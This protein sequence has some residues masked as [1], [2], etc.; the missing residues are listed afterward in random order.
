MR[1][2]AALGNSNGTLMP[3]GRFQAGQRAP[4]RRRCGRQFSSRRWQEFGCGRQRNVQTVR[5]SQ[6]GGVEGRVYPQ[7]DVARSGS[8]DPRRKPARRPLNPGRWETEPQCPGSAARHAACGIAARAG[9]RGGG[10]AGSPRCSRMRTMTAVSR[11][12]AIT[13]SS[14]PQ[15]EQRCMSISNTRSRSSAQ[16]MRDPQIARHRARGRHARCPG[17]YQRRRPA[18][19]EPPSRAAWRWV[20]ARRKANQLS[21]RQS[22]LKSADAIAWLAH[23]GETALGVFPGLRASGAD[24]L[25]A[26]SQQRIQMRSQRLAPLGVRRAEGS[27]RQFEERCLR[28]RRRCI[29]A[30]RVEPACGQS[31]HRF[32]LPSPPSLL[33][34][35][36]RMGPEGGVLSHQVDL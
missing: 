28:R 9:E 35:R 27:K 4:M 6:P 32:N 1:P 29:L 2:R 18:R 23:E 12:A 20:R 21:L 30:L 33:P 14:P 24:A 5:E 13:F 19:R 22:C 11:M 36:S 26:F 7:D 10:R 25:R 15:F 34:G 31:R 8:P 16:L 17:A 3:P